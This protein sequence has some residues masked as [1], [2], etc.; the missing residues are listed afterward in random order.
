MSAD[1]TPNYELVE[2]KQKIIK[3]LFGHRK[4]SDFFKEYDEL[5]KHFENQKIENYSDF[6]DL[7]K[8]EKFLFLRYRMMNNVFNFNI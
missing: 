1:E 5:K 6:V 2:Y 4:L 7:S 3:K 8:T